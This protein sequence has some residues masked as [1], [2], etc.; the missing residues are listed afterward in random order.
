MN[1]STIRKHSLPLSILLHLLPGI[2][3]GAAYYLLVPAVTSRGYP[4]ITALVGASLLILIPF[5]LGLLLYKGKKKGSKGLEGIVLYREKLPFQQYLIWVPVIFFSSGLILTLLTPV[6]EFLQG[7]FLWIPG[8]FMI[9][10]GLGGDYSKSVLILTYGLS[11]LLVTVISPTV[12]ELYFRG[13]LLPRMPDCKGW[14]PL[15]HT[16]L[17]ALYHTWT[18]WLALARTAAVLPLAYIVRWKKNILLGVIAHVLL[19]TID[20]VIGV[21]FILHLS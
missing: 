12:E 5:E 19:N 16:A 21:V 6:S 11:F 9:D 7:F 20:I 17:F 15:L 2:L 13:Y 14:S 1:T 3:T 8:E 18:P 10:M 4:T